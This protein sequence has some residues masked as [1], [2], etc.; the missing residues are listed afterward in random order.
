[1]RMQSASHLAA[2]WSAQGEL[3]A[4]RGDMTEAVACYRHAAESLQDFHF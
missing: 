4:A 3:A 1:M 2:V